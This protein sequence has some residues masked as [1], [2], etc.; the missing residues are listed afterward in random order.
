MSA[1]NL[2]IQSYFSCFEI[3]INLLKTFSSSP[4][5]QSILFRLQNETKTSF[6]GLT[7]VAT[8][9]SLLNFEFF[10]SSIIHNK[11]GLPV[12]KGI[13]N[14]ILPGKRVDFILA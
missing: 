7:E 2:T 6:S 9:I 10:N 8:M 1:V 12:P 11:M 13:G 3:A 4:L 14:R 5:K